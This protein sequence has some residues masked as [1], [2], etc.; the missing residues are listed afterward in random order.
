MPQETE[1]VERCQADQGLST[2]PVATGED[3]E[4]L[5]RV[6][7]RIL[8]SASRTNPKACT[9]STDLGDEKM[10]PESGGWELSVQIMLT[11]L[12]L[13]SNTI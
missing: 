4:V 10:S 3:I 11:M 1:Q 9:V 2:E 5:T 13:S 7:P 12:S 8:A 6:A